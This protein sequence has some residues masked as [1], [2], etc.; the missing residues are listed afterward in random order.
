MFGTIVGCDCD[1]ECTDPN[2]DCGCG[3]CCCGASAHLLAGVRLDASRGFGRKPGSRFRESQSQPATTR[4]SHRGRITLRGG[5][6]WARR[7]QD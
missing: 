1:P 2:C 3:G 5:L 6:S 4:W 7:A